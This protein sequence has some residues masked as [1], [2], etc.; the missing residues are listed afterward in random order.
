MLLNSN[1]GRTL[2]SITASRLALIAWVGVGVTLIWS[3][4][5]PG[6]PGNGS[7]LRRF[8]TPE[9][10]RT[11]TF[12]Q[13]FRMNRD[14][15]EAIEFRPTRAEFLASGEIRFAL[16]DITR[17][18]EGTV[19]RTGSVPWTELARRSSYRFEFAPVLDSRHK[20]YRFEIAATAERSGV[21]LVATRA[22]ERYPEGALTVNGKNRWAALLFQT[23]AS[24]ASIVST[25]WTGRTESGVPGRLVLALLALNW[26]LLGV[27]VRV[28]AGM[29]EGAPSGAPGW[30]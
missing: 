8:D 14:G 2:A 16:V 6:T 15:L 19:I 11:Y 5:Q 7:W 22:V 12:A 29:P 23:Y 4:A 27:I 9:I 21:A 18:D 17:E 13:R 26:L 10:T 24:N 20:A 3:L 28:L 1:P 25:L 30:P